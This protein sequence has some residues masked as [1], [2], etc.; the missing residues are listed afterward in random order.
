MNFIAR[1]QCYCKEQLE[2]G[3]RLL[4]SLLIALFIYLVIRLH[5]GL[6]SFEWIFL[7]PALSTFLLLLYYRIS[8]E[9]KDSKTD[10]KFFPDRPIPSGR[11]FLS[12]LK[13]MLA[14]VSIIAVGINLIYPTALKEF[15]IAFI[16]TVLMGKWFFMEKIIQ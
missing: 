12:D 5:N 9:F 13:I 1:I 7:I 15:M 6:T 4:L 10:Q 2:P 14:V 3:S 11:L 16:F 8:D